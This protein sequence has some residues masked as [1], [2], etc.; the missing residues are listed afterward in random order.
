MA[1]VLVGGG[2]CLGRQSARWRS[3]VPG[4]PLAFAEDKR[5]RM[6]WWGG[7]ERA[8]R[9]FK[10][11]ALYAARNP[12]VT[13]DGETLG[14]GDYWARLATQ[15]AGRNA[16]T[17][18]RW[19]TATSSNMP[20]AAPL[21]ARRAD[22]EGARHRRFGKDAIDSGRVDGKVYGVSLGSTRWPCSTARRLRAGRADA[23]DPRDDM[24][25]FA[26]LSAELTKANKG[27]YWGSMDGGGTEPA[28]EA[29]VR[30]RGKALY[31]PE[32]K[33]GFDATDAGDWLAYWTTCAS[34]RPAFRRRAVAR[35]QQ[36][37]DRDD[38]ARQGGDGLRAFEPARRLSGDQPAQAQHDD[39]SAGRRRGAAGAYLSR[40]RC[41]A[42]M[43]AANS[44]RRR[45]ASSISSSRTPK[46]RR[47]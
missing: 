10:V 24:G 11:N 44:P 30:Q 47:C 42:S 37:R 34:A 1:T 41:G 14:W 36:Q 25:T 2:C 31:T 27:A 43:R 22:A 18:C 23:A 45:R 5:L 17:S 35:P 21:A 32:G 8:D 38:L 26:E 12:G 9:T 3:A 29:W 33:L 15:A 20:G 28:F 46:P 19:T 39:V 7:K 6:Y 13:I 40:R 4:F 16:P